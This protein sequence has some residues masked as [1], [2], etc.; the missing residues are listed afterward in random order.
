MILRFILKKILFLF[1]SGKITVNDLRADVQNTKEE[2]GTDS[3]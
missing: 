3:D 1:S 2:F